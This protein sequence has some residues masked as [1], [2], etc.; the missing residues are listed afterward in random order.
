HARAPRP[1]P[2]RPVAPGAQPAGLLRLSARRLRHGR[3]PGRRPR[4]RPA[5]HRHLPPGPLRG[6]R[7]PRGGRGRPGGGQDRLR[8]AG[9]R[10]ED[11]T[12]T[13]L[14]QP[15][16]VVRALWERM[17]ARNWA[18]ARAT[19]ADDYRCECPASA[20]VVAWGG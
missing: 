8:R 15:G 14:I 19:L 1:R 13:T 5:G 4:A 10:T 16:T 6:R 3:R 12:V 11:T 17:E 7:R 20:G 2:P 9:R 18:G